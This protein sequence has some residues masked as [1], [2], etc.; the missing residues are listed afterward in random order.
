MRI[1]Q[2]PNA[3]QIFDELTFGP[4]LASP[5]I[6]LW[7]KLHI[8]QTQSI[9]IKLKN[10]KSVMWWVDRWGLLSDFSDELEL[11]DDQCHF[12]LQLKLPILIT[13][14]NYLL[15][16]IWITLT[17]KNRMSKSITMNAKIYCRQTP[18]EEFFLFCFVVTLIIYFI[19]YYKHPTK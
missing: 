12:Y 17:N 10:T 5:T 4:F 9:F 2:S 3:G 14:T 16:I 7:L 15:I 18:R 1:Y 11:Q 6:C 13:T 8:W 19:K